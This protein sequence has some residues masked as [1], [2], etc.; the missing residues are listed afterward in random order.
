M[1][2]P[3]ERISDKS[4]LSQRLEP[5][6]NQDCLSLSQND[7]ETD[8]IIDVIRGSTTSYRLNPRL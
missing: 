6:Q 7:S 3:E 8:P 2:F 4:E 1:P 5:L